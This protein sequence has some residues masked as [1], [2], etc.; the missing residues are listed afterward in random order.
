MNEQEAPWMAKLSHLQRA[1]LQN[2]PR[3]KADKPRPKPKEQVVNSPDVKWRPVDKT[4]SFVVSKANWIHKPD[5]FNQSKSVIKTTKKQGRKPMSNHTL[6]VNE[7]SE[8]KGPPEV[9]RKSIGGYEVRTVKG[10]GGETLYRLEDV[11]RLLLIMA[12]DL[13]KE[14][15]PLLQR[16]KDVRAAVNELTD[17]IGGDMNLFRDQVK[18]HLEE[19]RLTR[20]TMLTE[21]AQMS[22][23]LREIRQ[24]FIGPDYHN[25]LQRL[26][27]FVELCERLH[28]L[29][30]NGFLDKIADTMLNLSVS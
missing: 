13:P 7:A 2:R 25:E 4:A 18:K 17:G 27:D 28:Q 24:F 14:A 22:R 30:A 26:K 15:S 5:A 6:L 3:E 11:R 9:D 16:A 12:D 19:I 21:T 23:S 29:K 1:N 10:P 8:K 20:M